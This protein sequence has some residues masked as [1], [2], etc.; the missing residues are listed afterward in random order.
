MSCCACASL[1]QRQTRCLPRSMTWVVFFGCQFSER[2]YHL[3]AVVKDP[4][5]ATSERGSQK[6]SLAQRSCD[7]GTQNRALGVLLSLSSGPSEARWAQ[8]WLSPLGPA[9]VVGPSFWQAFDA[10]QRGVGLTPTKGGVPKQDTPTRFKQIGCLGLRTRDGPDPHVRASN[11]T[12]L[13]KTCSFCEGWR[14]FLLR[15][16]VDPRFSGVV[17]WCSPPKVVPHI[18][19]KTTP[20]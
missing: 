12:G 16:N 19:P 17:F 2:R 6:R 15:A 13:K 9:E 5:S 14:L 20:L 7:H 11:E 18:S 8:W 1:L 4:S 3:L 10:N